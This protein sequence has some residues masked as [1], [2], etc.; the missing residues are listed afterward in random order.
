M[1][2]PGSPSVSNNGIIE[3]ISAP[4]TRGFLFVGGWVGIVCI[5][6]YEI[7]NIINNYW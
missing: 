1:V 3:V 4:V 2:F 7:N 6:E 5:F